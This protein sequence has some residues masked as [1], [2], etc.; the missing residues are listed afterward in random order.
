MH[1]TNRL[2]LNTLYESSE[3]SYY[4]PD[5]VDDLRCT[6]LSLAMHL[7]R[8][9]IAELL[10]KAGADVNATYYSA[11][12]NP[13]SS[14][15]DAENCIML[16]VKHNRIELQQLMLEY[17]LTIDQDIGKGVTPL[18]MAISEEKQLWVE[19]LLSLGASPVQIIESQPLGQVPAILFAIEQY[20]ENQS[21]ERLAI[22]KLLAGQDGLCPLKVSSNMK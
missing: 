15:A 12:Y 18:A 6:A 21:S 17:G 1:F 4:Q 7:D 22:I 19:A 5:G 10:I 2:H 16:A 13:M 14:R 20:L 9:M 11:S 8:P 3:T